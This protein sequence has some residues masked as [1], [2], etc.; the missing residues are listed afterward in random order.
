MSHQILA[1]KMANEI[2]ASGSLDPTQSIDDQ[3]LKQS[4]YIVLYISFQPHPIDLQCRGWQDLLQMP[5]CNQTSASM[6]P[7]QQN[8]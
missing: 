5:R 3:F 2:H 6:P 4:I 1:L 8:E 7:F